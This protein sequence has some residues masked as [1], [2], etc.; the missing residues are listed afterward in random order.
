M[1]DF[2][3]VVRAGVAKFGWIRTA[4]AQ[5]RHHNATGIRPSFE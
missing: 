1:L 3:A 5:I 2:E 4:I